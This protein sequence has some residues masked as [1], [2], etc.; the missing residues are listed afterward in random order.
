MSHCSTGRDD[1]PRDLF[2]TGRS[3]STSAAIVRSMFGP[4]TSNATHSSSRRLRAV[5]RLRPRGRHVG[6]LHRAGEH[7]R[8][9]PVAGVRPS[10]GRGSTDP[11]DRRTCAPVQCASE[12][13]QRARSLGRRTSPAP[14]PPDE[15]RCHQTCPAPRATRS[16]GADIM[17]PAVASMSD[18]RRRRAVRAT[19]GPSNPCIVTNMSTEHGR[20]PSASAGPRRGCRSAGSMSG[21]Q[22]SASAGRVGRVAKTPHGQRRASS[23]R[24]RGSSS[25]L[26]FVESRARAG[27]AGRPS[28]G[29]GS[30]RAS[31]ASRPPAR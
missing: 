20:R 27:E 28:C 11:A 21:V 15:A 5:G 31:W 10:A 2:A 8:S 7:V 4:G 3:R 9:G 13:V 30:S 12:H 18:G 16:R 24:L 29:W 22:R 26:R 1:R 6:R 14:S 19:T 25:S 23:L 17:F